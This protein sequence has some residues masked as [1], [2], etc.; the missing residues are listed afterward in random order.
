MN[1]LCQRCRVVFEELPV[2]TRTEVITV[3]GVMV[4]WQK[5]YLVCP[6]CG[7]ELYNEELNDYNLKASWSA[8][9]KAVNYNKSKEQ[10]VQ[11][12]TQRIKELESII[13]ETGSTKELDIHDKV[14]IKVGK[15]TVYA[16]VCGIEKAK[17]SK[18]NVYILKR[19]KRCKCISKLTGKVEW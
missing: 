13:Q 10:D 8:W 1:A 6:D 9:D 7:C 2:H 17:N 4:D 11:Q 5:K 3:N 15:I 12:L 19:I 14:K 16:E 18:D